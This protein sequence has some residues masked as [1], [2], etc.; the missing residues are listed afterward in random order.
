MLTEIAKIQEKYQNSELNVFVIS[1]SLAWI[2]NDP[3]VTTDS[4]YLLAVPNSLDVQ[5]LQ[6][7][8]FVT[9]TDRMRMTDT[10][11]VLTWSSV[12]HC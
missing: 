11:D 9:T 8:K 12:L 5:T 2:K 1:T 10:S 7:W 6:K 3:Q 4:K